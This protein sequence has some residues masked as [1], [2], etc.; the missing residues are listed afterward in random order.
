[1]LDSLRK[2]LFLVAVL[3]IAVAMFAEMG[4]SL[5]PSTFDPTFM[6]AQAAQQIPPDLDDRDEV[7]EQTVKEARE[8]EKPP[9][10]AITYMALL[11]GLVLFTVLLMGAGLLLPE[12]IHGRIQGI[13]TLVVSLLALLAVIIMIILAFVKLLIMVALFT[14]VPFGTIAYLAIYGFFNRA[15]AAGILS[16]GMLLKLLFAGFLVLAHPRFMQNK[17]LVLIT[18]TTLVGGVIVSFL[19]GLVPVF[20]VSIT[21]AIAAIIVGILILIWAICLLIGSVI[22]VVK[23]VV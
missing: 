4:S 2:T 14:A 23:V 10:L 22:S 19:H 5:F 9:G 20:L 3:L 6:R 13:A 18:L 12:G 21:D 8:A 7:I 17:G 11:D 1:M 16:F 15:V